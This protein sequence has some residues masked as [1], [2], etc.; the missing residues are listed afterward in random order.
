[1]IRQIDTSLTQALTPK[2]TPDKTPAAN[3]QFADQLKKASSKTVADGS[4]TT[5]N[6]TAPPSGETW[7]PVEGHDDYAKILTGDRK[8]QYVNLNRGG[9]KGDAFSIEE[10]E[11]AQYHVY[12]QDG[13]DDLWVKV[14]TSAGA[15]AANTPKQAP[16]K[17]ETWSPVSGTSSYADILSGSRDGY[18][19]NISQG[20]SRQGD[21]F[22]IVKKAGKEYH[23]YGSGDSKTWVEVGAKKK[24]DTKST[25][26]TGSTGSTGASG[27]TT[28][29]AASTDSAAA[30]SSSKTTGKPVL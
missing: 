7:R 8:G 4:A 6:R 11:G 27:G 20:S 26:A 2:T 25:D 1:L 3:A 10:K 15:K 14:D 16:P 12:K 17:G 28:G 19:V 9:R 5:A 22:H 23:V 29:D 21:A 30:A 18:F 13:K 24:T